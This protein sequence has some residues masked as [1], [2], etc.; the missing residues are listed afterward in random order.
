MT[1]GAGR[2]QGG[3]VLP[4]NRPEEKDALLPTESLVVGLNVI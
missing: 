3:N 4:L 1:R 2:R